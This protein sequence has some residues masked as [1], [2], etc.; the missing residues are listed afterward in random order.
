MSY[1]LLVVLERRLYLCL[2]RLTFE[3]ILYAG[4]EV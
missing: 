1:R 4:D 2:L 3:D